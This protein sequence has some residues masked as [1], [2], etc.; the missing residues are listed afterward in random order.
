MIHS[1]EAE[2]DLLEILKEYAS[3]TS[4]KDRPGVIHCF[5][6]SYAFGQECLRLGFYL[7]F[8][9]ILT[10]KNADDIRTVAKDAPM[11][12]ILVET[13]SPFLA[14]MPHRGKTNQSSYIIETVKKLSEIKNIPFEDAVQKTADN[15]THLFK[16]DNASSNIP[17]LITKKSFLLNLIKLLYYSPSHC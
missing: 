14:P 15:A 13:D 8:S 11:D 7:S 16:L 1:R 4:L 6:G 10:F 3:L 9:G 17:L 5:S 12:K 2:S